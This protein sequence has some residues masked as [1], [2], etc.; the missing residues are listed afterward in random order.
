V[1]PS[2]ALVLSHPWTS[3]PEASV[4]GKTEL[5]M[6]LNWAMLSYPS[7]RELLLHPDIEHHP[8]PGAALLA[9]GSPWSGPG[10]GAAGVHVLP[11][12]VATWRPRQAARRSARPR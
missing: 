1:S 7:N 11:E 2:H 3:W 6:R 10:V 5:A 8:L 12:P 9:G 4:Q